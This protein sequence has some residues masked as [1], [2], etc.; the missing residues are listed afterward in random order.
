MSLDAAPIDRER[1]ETLLHEQAAMFT[2]TIERN[3]ALEA[4]VEELQRELGVW[5]LAMATAEKDNKALQRQVGSLNEDLI[6]VLIDGD[7]C[8]FSPELL[9]LGSNGGSRA[10]NILTRGITAFL[11]EEL[12]SRRVDIWTTIFLNFHGLGE[13]LAANNIATV[14]QFNAFVQAFNQSGRLFTVVD[15]G[16]GKESADSKIK[17]YLRTFARFPQTAKVIF[18]GAHDNGYS[19]S[20]KY[21]EHE[22][23]LS[24]VVLLKGYTEVA[25]ELKTLGLRELDIDNLFMKKK[26]PFKK[27][28]L[29]ATMSTPEIP[30]QRPPRNTPPTP[31]KAR[32]NLKLEGVSIGPTT[33]L[34][35]L[36]PPPC[37]LYYL[38]TC[39]A[40]DE[41]RY[42]HHYKLTPEQIE[43]VR[44]NAKKSPCPIANRG[45]KCPHGDKCTMG[46]VCPRG[47]KCVYFK[48][49]KCKFTGKNMHDGEPDY[50]RPNKGAA[51][52]DATTDT[53]D[54]DSDEIV[55]NFDQ[56]G[57]QIASLRGS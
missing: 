13:T 17:E 43:T 40:G 51:A 46:H 47:Y 54:G 29:L 35:K 19:A 55:F 37:N 41:C 48:Q 49:Q 11:E 4:R 2:A 42:G 31:S 28:G 1:W 18:G 56:M 38:S 22:G 9:A 16:K 53:M 24:K 30:T 36:N 44:R 39:P 7:G 6:L 26:I 8:I 23:L 34:H 5:K 12:G 27:P 52:A 45:Q 21:L 10:A 32:A 3:T 33:V 14:D 25:V 50:V 20:L 57:E 15:C